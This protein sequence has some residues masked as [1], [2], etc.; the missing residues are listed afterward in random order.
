[1]GFFQRGFKNRETLIGFT[2]DLERLAYGSFVSHANVHEPIRCYSEVIRDLERRRD[3]FRCNSPSNQ[4]R[5]QCVRRI[6]GFIPTQIGSRGMEGQS[7]GRRTPQNS[8]VADI[9]GLRSRP[10]TR[11]FPSWESAA[12][13]G[14]V[15]LARARLGP[16]RR[17]PLS[18]AL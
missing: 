2:K 4:C 16:A 1:M 11:V 6:D 17:G 12:A 9:P 18:A 14:S 3:L 7:F 13:V 8:V 5:K 15:G 10:L